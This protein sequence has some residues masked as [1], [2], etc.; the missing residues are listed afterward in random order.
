M[1]TA[2]EHVLRGTIADVE[3]ALLVIGWDFP[4]R[5]TVVFD[6]DTSVDIHRIKNLVV[7]GGEMLEDGTVIRAPVT[8]GPHVRVQFWGERPG[9]IAARLLARWVGQPLLDPPQE[10]HDFGLK[11]QT[12][13]G[14]GLY[15]RRP[16]FLHYETHT[17]A[18]LT[19]GEFGNG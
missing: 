10:S 5:G 17:K 11:M 9:P 13:N 19:I 16:S 15:Q 6:G 12:R 8:D 4:E 18:R 2:I 7:D 1:K 3:A 14:V